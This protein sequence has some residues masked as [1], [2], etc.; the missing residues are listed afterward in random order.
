MHMDRVSVAISAIPNTGKTT[1]FN[2]L[3]GSN[4]SVGNWPGVTVSKKQG[5]LR[6]DGIE[7]TLVDLPGTYS[8]SPASEEERVV[9]RYLLETP[10]KLILNVLDARN[11]Y[12]GLGLT[13]QLAMSGIPMVVAVNMMDEARKQ[14]LDIDLEILSEHLGAPVVGI[15]ARTGEG[16][17][18]L[19]ETLLQT[20]RARPRSMH[21]PHVSLPPVLEQNI[22]ELARKVGTTHTMPEINDTFVAVRLMEGG[23]VT[24]ELVR[25]KPAL[26]EVADDAKYR[27]SLVEKALGADLHTTCAQCRFNAAKGLVLETT[28]NAPQ[29]SDRLTGQIDQ[30]LLHRWLGLPL[31][32]VIM[33]ALFQGIY[34]LGTPLQDWVSAGF[35]GLQGSLRP[36]ALAHLPGWL[37]EFSV[38]GLLQGVGVVVTFLP[39][40]V[41]FFVFMSLI[42]DSGYMARAAFLMDRFMHLLKL[43]GKAFINILLGYGCNVP[44]VMGTRIL[45]SRHNRLLTLLLIPFSLCSARLQVFLFL[46]SILFAPRIAPL[47]VFGLYLGSF[48]AVVLT[49]L[50]LRLSRFG[51]DPEP[52]IMEMPPYRFPLWRSV[53]LRAWQEVKEFLYRA[54]TLIVTG[55]VIVWLLTHFPPG[56]TAGGPETFAGRIGMALDP[57]FDPIGIH[58]RETV[59]L[60][61]GFIA[62]EVVIGAMAVV[63]GAG[64]LAT[65]VAAAITPLQ[66]LS[67]MVFILLYTPCVATIGAIRAES[68][69]W[70]IALLSIAIGLTLAWTASFV[71]YQGGR[72]LGYA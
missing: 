45:A 38:D 47:V 27:R 31:F 19:R 15:V 71:V 12:R 57:L 33:F 44:A 63:Y 42:E 35:E 25:R 64:D 2:Q 54:A 69:S 24:E 58:W 60:I 11:L 22:M 1:L 34:A 17:E 65:H 52:F 70:R 5:H 6:L 3:T 43:D 46:A 20:L 48:V 13:L 56:A 21:P 61:F 32:F 23:A 67:F 36:W 37:V 55:V 62:K 9:R 28:H 51:G 68:R 66:G 50:V 49:G 7:V 18:R 39:I 41:L 53:G 8:I 4:Q 14:G 59:T 72:M 10:P 16:L 29:V 40:I 30:F 26:K